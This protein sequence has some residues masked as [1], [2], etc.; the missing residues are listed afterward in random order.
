MRGAG[1]PERK[2]APGARRLSMRPVLILIAVVTTLSGCSISGGSSKDKD[3]GTPQRITEPQHR[4]SLTD[5]NVVRGWLTALKLGDYRAAADFFASDALIQQSRRYRLHTR[6]QALA[7][8][9]SLPCRADLTKIVDEGDR[10]LATFKL[11]D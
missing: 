10:S 4:R 11:K 9:L 5:E 3:A 8:N 6:S 1:G 7:F 2:R